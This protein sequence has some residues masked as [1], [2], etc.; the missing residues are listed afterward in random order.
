MNDNEPLVVDDFH[1]TLYFDGPPHLSER[2]LVQAWGHEGYGCK[3][4]KLE[5]AF[6]GYRGE[7][8]VIVGAPKP[9]ESRRVPAQFPA[10]LQPEIDWEPTFCV[11]PQAGYDDLH[12]ATHE[13]SFELRIRADR[14]HPAK[15]HNEIV[16][17][18][19]GIHQ[20][21]PMC[22]VMLHYLDMIVGRADLDDFLSYANS[23]VADRPRQFAPMLAFGTF[24]TQEGGTTTAWT[25]GLEFFGHPNLFVEDKCLEPSVAVLLVFE[26]GHQVVCGTKYV[27]G[28]VAGLPAVGP[29]MEFA[30]AERNGKPVLQVVVATKV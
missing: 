9:I 25:T 6:H 11:N 16:A 4:G 30:A 1:A 22:A 17:A 5:G 20:V 14:A 10:V 18:L 29:R 27:A 12:R 13:A 15:A 26:L 2:A 24:V 8:Y 28:E 7:T 3:R 23:N 21:A 19:L